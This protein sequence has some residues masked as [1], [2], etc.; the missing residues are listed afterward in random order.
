MAVIDHDKRAA[1]LLADFEAGLSP[2][3]IAR[4]HR[5]NES[6]VARILATVGVHVPD[7]KKARASS[8][9]AYNA[10]RAALFPEPVALRKVKGLT[11]FQGKL[12][13]YA[14][15]LAAQ[16]QENPEGDTQ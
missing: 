8:L 5:I 4:K 6:N 16:F 3:E 7:E 13:D 15:Q 1:D 11:R 14:D 12:S 9:A 2:S 10:V